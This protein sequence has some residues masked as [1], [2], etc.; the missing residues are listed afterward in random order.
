VAAGAWKPV[1]TWSAQVILQGNTILDP[2]DATPI[3]FAS[4]SS[5]F[6]MDNVIR[7]R[8]NAGIPRERRSEVGRR[9]LE[10]GS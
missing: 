5:A 10:V 9:K 1:D 8:A 2:Q 4:S 3:R 7:G 6:L